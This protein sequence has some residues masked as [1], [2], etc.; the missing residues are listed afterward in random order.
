M[1]IQAMVER[2][3]TS[4]KKNNAKIAVNIGCKYCNTVASASGKVV[5][6]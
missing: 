5:T 1:T 6:A 2:C 3:I 4:F